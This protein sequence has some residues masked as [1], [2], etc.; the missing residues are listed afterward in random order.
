M[1]RCLISICWLE[2]RVI[3][4][5]FMM[6]GTFIFRLRVFVRPAGGRLTR[7][8]IERGEMTLVASMSEGKAGAPG[9]IEIS[10]RE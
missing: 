3:R 1:A 5:G 6:H 10:Q 8:R 4:G 9:C 2:H 7:L